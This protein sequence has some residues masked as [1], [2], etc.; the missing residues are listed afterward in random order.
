MVS[1]LEEENKVFYF[2][3]CEHVFGRNVVY[4]FKFVK[5]TSDFRD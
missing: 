3:S 4:G 2:L 1:D 5:F